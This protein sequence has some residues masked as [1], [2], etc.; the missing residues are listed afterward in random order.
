M[1]PPPGAQE[2]AALE[3]EM[4]A[5]Y[6]RALNLADTV[7]RSETDTVLNRDRLRSLQEQ[8][9]GV[10]M[11]NVITQAVQAENERVHALYREEERVRRARS[12]APRPDSCG[13]RITDISP[14]R[15]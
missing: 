7:W 4:R 10:V 9:V 5:Q 2:R 15:A 6:A 1:T 13:Q 3:E 11:A 14:A 12:S 8:Y